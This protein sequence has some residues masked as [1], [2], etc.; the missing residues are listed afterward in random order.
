MVEL[1]I[2]FEDNHLLIVNKPA[3]IATMGAAP[4]ED[5][6][7]N[8]AALSIKHRYNKPGNAFIGIVSRLDSQV[9]GALVL[10]RTSKAAA[11]LSQQFRERLPEKTYLAVVEKS[12]PPS[13][14]IELSNYMAK[15]ESAHRMEIVEHRHPDAQH[16]LLNYRVLQS[17]ARASLVEVQ[18]ITGRKHQIRV[19]LSNIGLPILGDRKY[20]SKSLFPAGIALHCQRLSVEHPT[21]HQTVMVEA[22][23]PASWKG[24]ALG[25]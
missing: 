10:A 4:G 2:L 24:L 20:G 19:Q 16:A 11:R 18:L 9:S 14:W 8:L 17:S 5:S 25:Q 12:L 6:V 21:G 15:N 7:A 3:G 23:L 1:P 13:A 22:P